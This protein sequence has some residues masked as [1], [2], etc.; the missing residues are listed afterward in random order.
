MVKVPGK[1]TKVLGY[2]LLDIIQYKAPDDE[3]RLRR[4][5]FPCC[6]P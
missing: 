3:K 1:I 2:Y 6:C 4:Y 5:I